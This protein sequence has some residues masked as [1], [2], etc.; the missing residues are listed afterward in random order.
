MLLSVLLLGNR[1]FKLL[2]FKDA[3]RCSSAQG[4]S[5]VLTRLLCE[6]VWESSTDGPVA[7]EMHSLCHDYRESVKSSPSIS[8]VKCN[9][10]YL[11]K[12]KRYSYTQQKKNGLQ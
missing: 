9:V 6:L 2:H 7:G 8:L 4:G 11:V 1:I 5:A 12:K 3:D 10:L